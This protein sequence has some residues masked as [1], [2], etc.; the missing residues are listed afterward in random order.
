MGK[1]TNMASYSLLSVDNPR[2]DLLRT[3]AMMTP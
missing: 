2:E 3:T 1:P